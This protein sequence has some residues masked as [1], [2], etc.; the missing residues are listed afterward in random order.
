MKVKICGLSNLEQV[1][2]CIKY[3]ADFCGFILNYPKSHR[4]ISYEKAIELTNIKKK[5]LNMLVY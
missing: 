3:N 1:E 5:I 4:F 2:A